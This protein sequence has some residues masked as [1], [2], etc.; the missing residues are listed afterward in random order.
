MAPARRAGG[1]R[2][3]RPARVYYRTT[4]LQITCKFAWKIRTRE[5]SAAPIVSRSEEP[6]HDRRIHHGSTTRPGRGNRP[7]D[8]SAGRP[9]GGAGPAEIQSGRGGKRAR[10]SDERAR[11]P[12]SLPADL[13]GRAPPA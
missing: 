10:G 6:T 5:L 8:G 9:G 2:R 13:R 4:A 12:Q 7:G 11:S 3:T 1:A